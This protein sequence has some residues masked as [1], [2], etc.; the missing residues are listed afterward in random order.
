MT[1]AYRE[2]FGACFKRVLIQLTVSAGC[3]F[4]IYSVYAGFRLLHKRM[5]VNLN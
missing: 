2:R 1:E 5:S 4:Q 3:M